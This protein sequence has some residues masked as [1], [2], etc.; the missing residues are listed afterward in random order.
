MKVGSRF[1][2][3]SN[4]NYSTQP[5]YQHNHICSIGLLQWTA[6]SE[7]RTILDK[8]KIKEEVLLYLN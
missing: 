4:A 8:K 2:Y 6:M 3:T 7:K 5:I 1:T